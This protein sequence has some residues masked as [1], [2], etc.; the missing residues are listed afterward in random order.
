MHSAAASCSPMPGM[1]WSASFAAANDVE[2]SLVC[3]SN[4]CEDYLSGASCLH[5]QLHCH[6]CMQ[7]AVDNRLNCIS[8]TQAGAL[9]QH[10]DGAGLKSLSRVQDLHRWKEGLGSALV[11][12]YLCCNTA[13]ASAKQTIHDLCNHGCQVDPM[14]RSDDCWT[15]HKSVP[16]L[17][18][19]LFQSPQQHGAV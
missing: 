2:A 17:F 19:V 15:S 5:C 18:L 6:L 9:L 3:S 14:R 12:G 11:Q 1:H 8:V 4:L 13:S 10:C 16:N 7:S